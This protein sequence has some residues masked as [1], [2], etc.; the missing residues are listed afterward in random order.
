MSVSKGEAEVRSMTLGDLDAI[1]LVDHK[2]RR[3]GKAVTY[4]NLTTERIF[5]IDRHIGS[6]ARPT[7]YVDLI[8]G[9]SLLLRTL[10]RRVTF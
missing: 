6:L 10:R 7:S 8:R 3:A 4:S 5:T 9:E 2:I 1:F